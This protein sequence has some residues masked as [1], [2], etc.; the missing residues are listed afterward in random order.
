VR[1]VSVR[2]LPRNAA[3]KVPRSTLLLN[4]QRLRKG[5]RRR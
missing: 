1:F 2:K 4:F 3:G 5:V